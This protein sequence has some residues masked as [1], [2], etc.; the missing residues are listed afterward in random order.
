MR[1]S[2]AWLSTLQSC[3][4]VSSTSPGGE[5]PPSGLLSLSVGLSVPP[6]GADL[7]LANEQS[8]RGRGKCQINISGN[9]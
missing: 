5:A 9:C 4:D 2:E 6:G 1:F 8:I 7:V 3:G